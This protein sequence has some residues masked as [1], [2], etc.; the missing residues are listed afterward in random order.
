M[1]SK[2]VTAGSPVTRFSTE[3]VLMSMAETAPSVLFQRTEAT[4]AGTRAMSTSPAT[5][6]VTTS[7][8]VPTM[9]KS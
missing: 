4:L 8:A 2:P 7:S 5:T 1:S 3:S 9:E 6:L